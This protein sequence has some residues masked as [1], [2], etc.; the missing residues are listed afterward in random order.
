[1]E[2]SMPDGMLSFFF[3]ED[4]FYISIFIHLVSSKSLIK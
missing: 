1:M 4:F 2:L 3:K